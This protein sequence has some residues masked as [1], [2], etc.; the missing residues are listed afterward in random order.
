MK[1]NVSNKAR[2][3]AAG[4]ALSVTLAIVWSMS[5][6]AHPGSPESAQGKTGTVELRLLCP[7]P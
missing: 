5:S 7:A 6:Y 3:S 1:K 4:V 2:L